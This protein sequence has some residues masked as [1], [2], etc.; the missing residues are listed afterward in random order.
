MTKEQNTMRKHML[1]IATYNMHQAHK[2]YMQ[3]RQ[4]LA[5][6]NGYRAMYPNDE[7]VKQAVGGMLTECRLLKGHL[8]YECNIVRQLLDS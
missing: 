1:H 5:D 4:N 3:A 7:D 2:E 6:A 8:K